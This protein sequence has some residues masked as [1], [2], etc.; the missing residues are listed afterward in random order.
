MY[1]VKIKPLCKN[2][3]LSIELFVLG[4]HYQNSRHHFLV[5]SSFERMAPTFSIYI[6]F[7]VIGVNWRSEVNMTMACG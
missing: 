4:K 3:L 5:Q 7:E 6:D 1:N 2:I